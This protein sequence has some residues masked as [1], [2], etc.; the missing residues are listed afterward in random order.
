MW[1]FRDPSRE[2]FLQG[3][4]PQKA[5]AHSDCKV[6]VNMVHISEP[7]LEDRSCPVPHLF[8]L[9]HAPIMGGSVYSLTSRGRQ[10]VL[11]QEAAE[12]TQTVPFN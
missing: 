2:H 11:S 6:G 3:F 10:R 5:H 12:A 8:P 4:L 9:A 1:T 7:L